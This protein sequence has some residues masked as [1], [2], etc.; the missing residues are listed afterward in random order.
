LFVVVVV[1]LGLLLVGWQLMGELVLAGVWQNVNY[2]QRV[3]TLGGV[4]PS[5]AF[6]LPAFEGINNFDLA[7]PY[8]VQRMLNLYIPPGIG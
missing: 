7:I 1:G 2:I 3:N 8:Q 4:V 6:T 5:V